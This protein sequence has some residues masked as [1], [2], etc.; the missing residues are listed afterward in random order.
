MR[1][2]H[3]H[4]HDH[5]H[6]PAHHGRAFAIGIALN[7]CFV[8]VEAIYGVLAHSLSLV[9]DAGHNL[10]DV[11]GL[12]LAWGASVL[13]RRLPTQRRTY[14]L[15]RSSILVSLF[16]ALVL[17]VSVG[18]IAWEAVVRLWH[19]EPVASGIVMAVA[20]I[21]IGVN[22]ITAWLFMA[23]Q[24]HDVN[25]RGAFMHMASDAV[26]SLGVVLAAL[27]M[28]YTGWLWLDPTV[29][30][31]IVVVIAIS[32]WSL[33]S[34]SL[35]LALDA[36]PARIDPEEVEAWL[37]GLP[38]VV[39]VHDLHIWGMSTTEAALTVHLVKPDA[40]I[41]DALLAR[42]NRELH[43]KFGINHVTVQFELGDEAHPCR[44]A[45][46]KSG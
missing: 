41:D 34:E 39:A 3:D 1:M 14:G 35:D 6:A 18:A 43:A 32:T 25:I 8:V 40:S 30:L 21:G 19:P 2:G 17:L 44:Q 29:S 7:L 4:S 15:R 11:L 26:I 23:G 33:L 36:V 20:A 46:L 9:A 22:G 16:N 38:N 24:Q 37:A 31:I 27:T 5:S 45:S 42:I 28:R 13:V 10:S 12:A